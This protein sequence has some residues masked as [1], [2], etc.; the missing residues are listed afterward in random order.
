MPF[1]AFCTMVFW[2]F[3]DSFIRLSIANQLKSS[4]FEAAVDSLADVIHFAE[5]DSL[6]NSNVE[7][8]LNILTQD[9]VCIFFQVSLP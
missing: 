4:L 2:Y 1:S 8:P 6:V 3:S 5:F 9:W 7:I